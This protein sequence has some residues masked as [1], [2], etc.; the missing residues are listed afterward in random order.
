M[1]GYFGVIR[2]L[3]D[4][5]EGSEGDSMERAAELM[6]AALADGRV[7][8]Y[9]GAG[10]SHML[11]DELFYRAGGLVPVNPI[12]EPALMVSGGASKSTKMEQLPGLASIIV[13]ESGMNAGDVL[14]IA[15]NSGTNQVPVEMASEAQR[16]GVNVIAL[17]SVSSSHSI[18][19]R[20]N[21]KV[22]LLD[23]AHVVIDTH[24]PYGDAAVKVNGVEQQIGPVSTAIGVAII[25][26]LV[27]RIV[28]KLVQRGIDPPVFASANVPGGVER[29]AAHIA[30][31]KSAIRAL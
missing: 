13:S 24:V 1:F 2:D 4:A 10:H 7:L 12:Q 23:C 16:L 30:R 26:S 22:R 31:Y 18:P 5:V 8:Y 29:N 17:T 28:E 15:S 3:L 11:G 25:N 14:I 21:L 9:F 27:V 20:N 6:A 19:V